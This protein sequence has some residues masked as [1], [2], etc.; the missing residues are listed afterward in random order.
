M[1]REWVLPMDVRLTNQ[2]GEVLTSYGLIDNIGAYSVFD[3][4]DTF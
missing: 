3:F 1:S 2:N 4:G